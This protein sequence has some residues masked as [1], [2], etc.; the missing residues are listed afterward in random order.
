M[1]EPSQKKLLV[2]IGA[3]GNQGG[4]VAR[5]FLLDPSYSVRALTRNPTSPAVELGISCRR[6]AYDVEARQGRNIADAAAGVAEGLDE[7][8][9][10]VSTLSSARECS[11]GQSH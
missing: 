11:G 9:F 5:R 8:G 7:N 2:V 10:W 1:T 3:T 6:Y 4:S